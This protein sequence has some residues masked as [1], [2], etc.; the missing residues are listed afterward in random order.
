MARD[1]N[2]FLSNRGENIYGQVGLLRS[3]TTIEIDEAFSQY[4]DCMAGSP[5]CRDIDM[6]GPI[7]KLNQTEL[8]DI[9]YVLKRPDLRELYD[10]TEKFIRKK[11]N[12]SH[13]PSEAS[14]YFNALGEVSN[15][16]MFVIVMFLFVEKHQN[17]AK[18]MTIATLLFFATVSVQLKM[19]RSGNQESQVIQAVNALP[20]LDKFCYFEI[21]FIIK[22]IMYGSLFNAIL[23]ISRMIDVDPEIAL[24]GKIL[25]AQQELSKSILL[26]ELLTEQRQIAAE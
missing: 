16:S 8:S 13:V 15:Y 10:K 4:R 3:A 7:Y 6:A 24:K 20:F 14:R 9:E 22:S 17:F 1:L 12:P 25:A 18:Q 26:L 2:K 11:F 19:P 23:H 21:N 5:E